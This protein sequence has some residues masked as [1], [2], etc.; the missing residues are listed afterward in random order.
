MGGGWI[1]NQ[2]KRGTRASLYVYTIFAT[3]C[4][5]LL[6]VRVCVA[7]AAAVATLTTYLNRLFCVLGFED[8]ECCLS[9]WD[10]RLYLP[11]YVI[12][13][14]AW[15]ASTLLYRAFPLSLCP[16]SPSFLHL[17]RFEANRTTTSSI[18]A[19]STPPQPSSTYTS[20]YTYG[21]TC[22]C[23]IAA[24]ITTTLYRLFIC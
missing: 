12:T 9:G 14:A 8:G 20:T 16:S 17:S 22:T 23:V 13:S 7:T 24:T 4:L 15:H 11:T 19:N 1:G 3:I 10:P 2:A 21:Y 18:E 5:G 6:R